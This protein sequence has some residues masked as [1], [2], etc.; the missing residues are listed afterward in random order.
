MTSDRSI[1]SQSKIVDARDLAGMLKKLRR[2]GKSIVFTNGCFD[3]L[4]VGHVRY[5]TAARNEGDLLIIGLNSDRSVTQIKGNRRPIISQ[6]RRAEVLAS[7]STVDYVTLFDEPDPLELIRLLKPT[8][9]VKGADWK[10]GEIIGADYVKSRGGRV[11]RVPLV[12]EV[13]TTEIIERIIK[14]FR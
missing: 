8:I 9:I 3:L 6:S 14:R 1:D 2:A 10:A 5:L 11:I 7:L 12:E 13:S 4:H